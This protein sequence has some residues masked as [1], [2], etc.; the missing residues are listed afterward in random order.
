MVTEYLRGKGFTV[1]DADEIARESAAPGEPVLEILAER[2]GKRI[3]DP[4]G[5]LDRRKLAAIVFSDEDKVAGL[6]AIMHKDIERRIAARVASFQGEIA[7]LSA[8][9]LFESG[10]DSLCDAVWLVSAS[11]K[12]RFSR[13]AERDEAAEEEI[14]SRAAHQWTEERRRDK[15]QEIIDNNGSLPDLYARVDELLAKLKLMEGKID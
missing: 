5:S 1:W 15:A 10:M 14:K 8:P 4:D 9:L 12:L 13:A 3:I 2:F 6:N 7:F 11:E